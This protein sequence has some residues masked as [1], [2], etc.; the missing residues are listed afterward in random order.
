M[1]GFDAP[2]RELQSRANRS[3]TG[4]GGNIH[5]G[6]INKEFGRIMPIE[7][8]GKA[9]QSDI[10]IPSHALYDFGNSAGN[11]VEIGMLSGQQRLKSGEKVPI[12]LKQYGHG[13]QP[14]ETPQ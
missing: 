8:L 12:G 9:P 10:P 1:I 14:R 7:Q 11:G 4:G 2:R 3:G 13:R 5:C 6:V